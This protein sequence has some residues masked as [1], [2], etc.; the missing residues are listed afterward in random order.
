MDKDINCI[1]FKGLLGY[2]ENEF[3][4][5][6]L[7]QF[8]EEAFNS[9][10][11]L[12]HNKNNPG[13][14]EPVTIEHLRDE[15]YWI[16]NE[17]SLSLLST[18]KK[19]V[20]VQNPEITTG[21]KVILKNLSNRDLF[22]SKIIGPLN[23]V[24]KAGRINRKFNRT[25]D[26]KISI[27]NNNKA[28]IE[29]HY[30]PGFKVTKDVCNW[31]LGIY[32]GIAEISGAR[33]VKAKEVKCILD[34]DDH[35]E[36]HMEY[37]IPS[38]P[39]RIYRSILGFFIKGLIVEYEK[40]VND[41]DRLIEKLSSSHEQYRLLVE[42]QS[43]MVIRIDTEGIFQFVS[44]SYCK[45]FGQTEKELLGSSIN[46]HIHEDDRKK[47]AEELKGVS[48]QLHNSPIEKRV[49]TKDGYKW[50]SWMLT[51][52]LDNNGRVVAINGVG[53]DV[54]EK[55]QIETNLKE[56]EILFKLITEN[57]SALFS[58]HDSKG[59]YIFASPSHGRLG[60]NPEDLQG[61]SGFTMT[62]EDDIGPLIEKLVQA[63]NGKLKKVYT[64]YRLIDKDGETHYFSGSFDAV[65]KKDGSLERI[66]SVG[67]NITGV[68]R[69]QDQREQALF[70]A[71]EAKKMALVGQIAGKMAHDFN[72]ILS[73]IMG[74]SELSLINCDDGEIKENLELIFSQTIRGKNLTRNLVAFAKN[75]EPNQELFRLN[76]IINQVI[77][78]ME[79]DLE[80]ISVTI[81]Q[82]SNLPELLADPSMIE[83]AIVNMFQNSIDALSKEEE[84]KIVIRTYSLNQ[85]ICFEIEDNGCGIGE[86]YFDNIYDPSFTLKGSK[87]NTG[88]YNGDIKGTGYG[89][90]NVKKYVKQHNGKITVESDVGVGTKFT[91]FLPIIKKELSK[92]E[93]TEIL[94]EIVHSEK[95]ILLVE[96][97]PSIADIQY[98][99][100]TQEPCNHKV[101]VANS[102]KVAIELYNSNSYDFISL[103]YIL[104]GNSNGMDVYKHIREDNKNIPIIFI[105][106]N[107][108][109]IESIEDLKI[110]DPYIDHLSK[111]CKNID[112][113]KAL[114]RLMHRTNI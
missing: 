24:K 114:N 35:C 56:S 99:V 39:K 40:T 33:F 89:M 104:A 112:Y 110:K 65:F 53:R 7:L 13:V 50:I 23:L 87:D 59:D 96:D 76:D 58:I 2:I 90:A 68:V 73:I 78:P 42:N 70:M 54:T 28:I 93:K 37:Q 71:A 55:K 105:S 14:V 62:H 64:N 21:R 27:M 94:N 109:F 72:N 75:R 113:V 52:V 67:E 69:A 92:E 100:L 22:F 79:N 47:T 80:N 12:I 106:G 49:I 85:N 43:D 98:R 103:D 17:L 111:P 15:S 44:P 11:Y 61:K 10:T 81:D 66:I 18:I 16:S 34:G 46:N 5:E 3:G 63:Q 82:E 101:D 31:N 30:K 8:V 45:M 51:A 29:L 74:F 107:I 19:Y 84:P 57:T 77:D 1:N 97:E 95:N 20:K 108:E 83:H 88:A 48:R 38:F 4:K 91:I 32:I 102:G 25:K 60:Y 9:K 26:I 6:V 86:E 36:I 41:R